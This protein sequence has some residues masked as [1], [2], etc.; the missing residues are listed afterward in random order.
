MS[1]RKV[2]SEMALAAEGAGK[3]VYP[4]VAKKY[5]EEVLPAQAMSA[6]NY[7]LSKS[8]DVDNASKVHIL[9]HVTNTASGDIVSLLPEVCAS[10]DP[11]QDEFFW[12]L[13]IAA[14]ATPTKLNL[15]ATPVADPD[16]TQNSK[17]EWGSMTFLPYEIRTDSITT[18][19]DKLSLIIT[20]DVP[21]GRKFRVQAGSA[22]GTPTVSIQ[23][24]KSA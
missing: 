7:V 4:I 24:A 3:T 17:N 2:N 23:F 21:F 5:F 19:N 8:I 10:D 12:P 16:S 9:V 6:S 13:A 15:T 14:A 22:A 11:S 20:V 18:N 1:R